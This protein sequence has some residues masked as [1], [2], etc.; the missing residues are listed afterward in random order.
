ML[1]N[2][3]KVV[4]GQKNFREIE[5]LKKI[6]DKNYKHKKKRIGLYDLNLVCAISR[7]FLP[8]EL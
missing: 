1:K 5:F 6:S 7:I 3:Y 8:N 2:G 4:L